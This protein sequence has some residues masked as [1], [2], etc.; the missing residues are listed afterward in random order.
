MKMPVTNHKP[1]P[2]HVPGCAAATLAL[3][4][5]EQK[6]GERAKQKVK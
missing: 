4:E 6:E 5:G 3:K 2:G 1:A